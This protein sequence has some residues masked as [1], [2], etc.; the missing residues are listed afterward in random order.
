MCLFSYKEEY[1]SQMSRFKLEDSLRDELAA[2]RS[3]FWKVRRNK[4]HVPHRKNILASNVPNGLH[5]KTGSH[6]RTSSQVIPV[7]CLQVFMPD[8]LS[9]L[10]SGVPTIDVEDWQ[11]NTEV[12][13][14]SNSRML[15]RVKL[16]S[17]LPTT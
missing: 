11:R 15:S 4:Q 7:R 8:E 17:D 5:P 12:Q 9:L 14:Q 13:G 16:F 3:G 10:L 1:V 2:F 6:V